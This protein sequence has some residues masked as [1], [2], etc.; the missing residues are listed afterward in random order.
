MKEWLESTMF[1]KTDIQIYTDIQSCIINIDMARPLWRRVKRTRE[2][3]ISLSTPLAKKQ[4]LTNL[5]NVNMRLYS[6]ELLCPLPS[7]LDLFCSF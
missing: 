2:I 3:I 4:T 7:P 6:A 5:P 1:M